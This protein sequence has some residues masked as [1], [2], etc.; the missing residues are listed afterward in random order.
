[1]T[2]LTDDRAECII[3]LYYI[4]LYSS[5]LICNGAHVAPAS[6]SFTVYTPIDAHKQTDSANLYLFAH[7]P[8]Y[9]IVYSTVLIRY[10]ACVPW[11]G[12][13]SRS[14][15]VFC[16]VTCINRSVNRPRDLEAGALL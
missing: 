8:P 11:H 7:F 13:Q 2:S 4:I 1:M 15:S 10:G 16:F 12:R 14:S 9:F 6:T 3:L 5:L